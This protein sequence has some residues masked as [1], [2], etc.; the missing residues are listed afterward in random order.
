MTNIVGGNHECPCGRGH[1]PCPDE[2]GVPL[3][4]PSF[5]VALPDLVHLH[6]EPNRVARAVGTV[7]ELAAKLWVSDGGVERLFHE[8]ATQGTTLAKQQEVCRR[9]ARVLLENAVAPK[10]PAAAPDV[11]IVRELRAR[12]DKISSLCESGC[13]GR[14]DDCPADALRTTLEVM[15]AMAQRV[16]EAARQKADV[17]RDELFWFKEYHGIAAKLLIAE[18]ELDRVKG[19]LGPPQVDK[20]GKPK[21]AA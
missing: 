16:Q 15:D 4:A 5:G 3:C 20:D 11:E 19:K 7:E 18:A 9:H 1:F 17:L 10:P 8:A 21:D 14:C 6:A 13:N 2:N 12:W